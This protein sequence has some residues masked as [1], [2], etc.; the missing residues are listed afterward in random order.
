MSTTCH[1]Q[2]FGV[3]WP[4]RSSFQQ[5]R[6]AAEGSSLRHWGSCSEFVMH[7]V[8]AVM[9]HWYYKKFL[10]SSKCYQY[11]QYVHADRG[12]LP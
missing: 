10:R 4:V 1:N 2:S 8:T 7:S 9:S 12:V 6:S 3:L 5:N 11:Y